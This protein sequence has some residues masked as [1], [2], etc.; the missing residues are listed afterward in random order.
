VDYRNLKLKKSSAIARQI[1]LHFIDLNRAI[2]PVFDKGNIYRIP[3]KQYDRFRERDKRRFSQEMSRL[4]KAGF[5]KKYFDGK[6]HWVELEPRGKVQIKRFLTQD[7]EIASPSKWDRKWRLVIYDIANDKK[8]KRQIFKSKLEKLGFRKLQESVYVFPFDCL[9]MISLMKDMYYLSPH[10]Q[11]IVA[12]RIETET[13][14][15]KH[16]LDQGILTN[17][18]L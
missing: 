16:F 9:D 2:L 1:L 14:L 7:L 15:I 4:A 10:I 11:Y 13:N 3:F 12:D 8:D 18:M 5:I 6:E 17:K